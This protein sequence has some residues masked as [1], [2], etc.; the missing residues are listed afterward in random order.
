MPEKCSKAIVL[1]C[2]GQGEKCSGACTFQVCAVYDTIP[3]SK[4]IKNLKV[5]FKGGTVA[6]PLVGDANELEAAIGGC[7]YNFNA[8]AGFVEYVHATTGRIHRLDNTS[9]NAETNTIRENTW[10][11]RRLLRR[12]AR[13]QNKGHCTN[14]TK[15][16]FDF[17]ISVGSATT[18][19]GWDI[20][21]ICQ[22][23]E[24]DL[25][26]SVNELQA[27]STAIIKSFNIEFTIMVRCI[28]P[29]ARDAAPNFTP[30]PIKLSGPLK[31]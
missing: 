29:E 12:I 19:N 11:N 14:W 10:K 18:V 7:L 30:F 3:D 25:G 24:G 8:G 15:A 20:I 9:Y 31:K 28:C 4:N 23:S 1:A 2:P 6:N 22:R 17:M 21:W 26:L 27:D 5:Q 13:I 16:E